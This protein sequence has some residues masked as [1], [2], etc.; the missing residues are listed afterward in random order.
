MLKKVTRWAQKDRIN[1]ESDLRF[2][3]TGNKHLEF[4]RLS[5]NVFDGSAPFTHSFFIDGS[6]SVANFQGIYTEH[7][8]ATHGI[9]VFLTSFS[10][11]T[12]Q[13]FIR[14]R[15]PNGQFQAIFTSLNTRILKNKTHWTL[16]FKGGPYTG[17]NSI[18]ELYINGRFFAQQTAGNA[19]LMA[20]SL[21]NNFIGSIGG[22][23]YSGT[24]SNYAIFDRELTTK[25]IA[26]I[27]KNGGV[28]PAS[29]HI[30]CIAHYPLT[31]RFYPKASAAF[32]AKHTQLALNNLVAFDVVEQYNYAKVTPL[33]ANHAKLVNFTDAEAGA[34][35]LAPI[36]TAVKDFYTKASLDVYDAPVQPAPE[37]NI[38]TLSGVAPV[39]SAFFIETGLSFATTFANIVG[40]GFDTLV[41]TDITALTDIIT[42]LPTITAYY[43]NGQKLANEA[44]LI[45]AININNI[46]HIDLEFATAS[47]TV[48]FVHTGDDY[49]LLRDYYL[50]EQ[51]SLK[52][53]NSLT[54][55]LLLTNPEA[56]IQSKF[57]AYRNLNN[58]SFYEN[59]S[60]VLLS[61]Q[62][63][64]KNATVSGLTGA[65]SADQL[66]DVPNHLTDINELR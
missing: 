1:V 28:L 33:T 49:Y 37:D 10:G 22:V 14:W 62:I 6:D 43:F 12:F 36:G 39:A 48:T 16:V 64:S 31:Q 25:E 50:S 56:R 15:G 20:Q 59:G 11:S 4:K 66:A 63:N 3:N 24:I 27:Y 18:T 40:V 7:Q 38:E 55:N 19:G 47:P 2:E 21:T 30:D 13:M 26:Y 60:N 54:N 61:D 23:A 53:K 5:T 57:A 52:E 34:D 51:L 35:G 8:N 46:C 17:G 58:A 41:L 9:M 65:T 29:T 32:I 45:T 44:A 42:G